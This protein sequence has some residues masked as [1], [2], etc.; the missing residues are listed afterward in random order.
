[1]TEILLGEEKKEEQLKDQVESIFVEVIKKPEITEALD[2]LDKLPSNLTYHNKDHTLDVIKETILFALGNG[3]GL[4]T[5]FSE[6]LEHLA[7]AAAWHDVGYL[8]DPKNHEANSVKRF[9]ES[10]TY[11]KLS[12][13][14]RRE[15]VS[16][17]LDTKIVITNGTPNIIQAKSKWGYILDADVSNFGRDDFLS[18]SSK[19]VAELNI[20]LNDIETKKKFLKFTIDLLKNQEW[21]TESARRM[22]QAKKEE[23]IKSMEEEYATL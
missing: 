21:K 7:I 4:E 6:T 5:Y 15:I 9:E 8:D 23:N 20:N 14:A 22:R 1:M 17:I 11:K 19:V 13:E 18:N 3:L 12:D 2:L 10:K 16:N